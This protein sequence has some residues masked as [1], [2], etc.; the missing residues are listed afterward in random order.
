[1]LDGLSPEIH[2][3]CLRYLYSICGHQALVP[4]SLGI[5]LCYDPAVDPVYRGEVADL[6]KGQHEGRKVAVQVLRLWPGDDA[7]QVRKVSCRLCS[8]LVVINNPPCLIEVLQGGCDMEVAPSSKR[9]AIVG[10]YDD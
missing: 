6:W 5:P 8:R 1:M 7:E 10:R 4:R 9:G 2:R 3:R